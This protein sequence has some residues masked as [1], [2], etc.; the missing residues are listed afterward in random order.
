[1]KKSMIA[2]EFTR[3]AKQFH[4]KEEPMKIQLWGLFSWG[5]VSKLIKTGEVIPNPG[6]TKDNKTIWCK[7]SQDFF[8]KDIKPLIDKPLDELTSLA[9]W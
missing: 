1:M 7:P 8:E 3:R 9:G 4:P 5:C 6:F 2:A